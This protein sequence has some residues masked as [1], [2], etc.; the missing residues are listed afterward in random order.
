MKRSGEL[1]NNQRTAEK[2][3]CTMKNTGMKSFATMLDESP[4]FVET[5]LSPFLRYELRKIAPEV[6]TKDH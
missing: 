6:V 3:T 5:L 4:D 1:P 2:T